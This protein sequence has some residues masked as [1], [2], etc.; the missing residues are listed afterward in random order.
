MK[1]RYSKYYSSQRPAVVFRIKFYPLIIS[2][3]ILL[4]GLLHTPLAAQQV[5]IN[6]QGNKIVIYPDGSWRY[7]EDSDSTLIRSKSHRNDL[8]RMPEKEVD[9]YEELRDPRPDGEDVIKQ[10]RSFVQMLREEESVLR[11]D[12]RNATTRKFD[13]ET[14]LK[15]AYN[16]KDIV[17]PD[18]LA[19]LEKQMESQT[20][21]VKVTAKKLRK[22]TKI[23]KKTYGLTQRETED[24]FTDLQKLKAKYQ[25]Y[26]AYKSGLNEKPGERLAD[27]KNKEQEKPSEIAGN[28]NPPADKKGRSLQTASN[29]VSYDMHEDI[30]KWMGIPALNYTPAASPCGYSTR[31]KDTDGKIV[32]QELEKT[33]IFTHT[34]D[35]LRPYFGDD[36]LVTCNASMLQLGE[37][38][39]LNMDFRIASPNAMKNFGPLKTGSLLRIKLLNGI[40]VNLYNM[41]QD[42]GRIDPYSGHTLYS[43]RYAIGDSER[44]SLQR[45]GVEF[46]RVVWG[47]GF[48][49]YPV[50]ALDFFKDQFN[51]LEK[52]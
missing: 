39:Y 27:K 11:K 25:A 7:Y 33:T 47:T 46:V 4:A 29:G 34:D 35:E 16:N 41:R 32:R 12:L 28:N 37:N 38:Y 22:V 2:G 45:S 10:S 36:E 13:T 21:E 17:E 14:Q 6:T 3:L 31:E 1:E 44:R 20:E 23:L 48:E 51:C 18:L 50:Y 40:Y 42:V 43:G 52:E 49:D 26:V 15:E 8:T 30:R 9:H 5:I 19:S 24:Q